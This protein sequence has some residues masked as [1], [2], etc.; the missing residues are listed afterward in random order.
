MWTP[1]FGCFTER[2]YV[3]WHSLRKVALE[4]YI[5]KQCECENL[6]LVVTQSEFLIN[7]TWP[8]LYLGASPDGGVYDPSDAD[9]PFG[10]VIFLYL[11]F[12]RL[13]YDNNTLQQCA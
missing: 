12:E 8:Y 1:R 7:P 13:N 3:V 4:A 5:K 6:D 10:I 11:G 9:K 2:I